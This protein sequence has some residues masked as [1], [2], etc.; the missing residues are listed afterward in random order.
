MPDA[1][2]STWIVRKPRPAARLRLFC[3][4]Y[5]GGGAGA[6]RGWS[7]ALPSV[8]VCAVQAPGRENRLREPA[9]LRMDPLVAEIT[10]VVRAL[11]DLPFAF[12]G[13][14]LGAFI[15]FEVARALRR[16]QAP[17]PRHLFASGCPAPQAHVVDHPIH[18][19]TD[20]VL[21]DKLRRYQGTPAGVLDN[22]ELMALLLP[23]LRAD[24]TIYETYQPP[25]SDEPPLDLPLT[26]LGGLEDDHATRAQLEAWRAQT[27]QRF[28]L[29]MFPGGHFFV[30]GARAQVL[31]SVLTD[32][33]PLLGVARA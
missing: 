28:V 22:D 14:S 8:E 17:L 3:F 23:V 20:A 7:D 2:L 29:R 13:H 24:F 9:F 30:H 27:S 21:M 25:P 18:G 4:P 10:R 16:E 5:S 11:A 6:F 12:F 15:A 31:G 32:L 33:A 19:D 1:D 26:A